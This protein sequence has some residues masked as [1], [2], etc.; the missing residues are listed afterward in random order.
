MN[1]KFLSNEVEKLVTI[2]IILKRTKFCLELLNLRDDV[3]IG[4]KR[5]VLV[6]ADINKS[7]ISRVK[8]FF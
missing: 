4:T 1:V 5:K 2:P 8:M 3:T 7:K 6:L